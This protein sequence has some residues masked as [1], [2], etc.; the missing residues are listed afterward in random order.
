MEPGSASSRV[1]GDL[2]EKDNEPTWLL[3]LELGE[4]DI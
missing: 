1:N 3:I 4:K 2:Q